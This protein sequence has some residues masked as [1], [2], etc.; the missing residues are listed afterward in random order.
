MAGSAVRLLALLCSRSRALDAG[1]VDQPEPPAILGGRTGQEP[2]RLRHSAGPPLPGAQA[3]VS[4]SRTGRDRPADAAKAGHG[5]CAPSRGRGGGDP[6]LARAGSRPSA[7]RVRAPR[8]PGP[9]GAAL[10]GSALD[11][12]TTAWV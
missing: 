7:N 1:D 12:H 5:Q 8:T 3:L 11:A 6:G 10:D 9:D 4:H 2:A